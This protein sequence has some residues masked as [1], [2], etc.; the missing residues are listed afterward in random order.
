[1]ILFLPGGLA[2]LI[3]RRAR[4]PAGRGDG[5]D[6]EPASRPPAGDAGAG[7]PLLRLSGWARSYGGVHA[8]RDVDLELRRGEVLGLI[9]P[10]GA[11]KTT[12]VN[13][14]SGLVPPTLGRGRRS[15]AGARSA[16]RRCTDRPRAGREP[17][18]PALQA[19][20]PALGAF[21]NVLV[22]AHLRQPPDVPARGCCGCPRPAATSRRP[23]EQA[24]RCLRA[25]RAGRRGRRPAR[26]LSYGDQRRLE[27][28]RALAGDPSLLILDEPAAGMNHVEAASWRR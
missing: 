16:A 20:R 17:H 4:T 11:G 8:V 2:S 27:I 13:M 26:Q 5:D 7:E 9:G 24:A 1:M 22:G 12:L 19:V 18:V 28:A 14:I 15:S 25:R 3:P 6:A 21:E 23:L 10:N